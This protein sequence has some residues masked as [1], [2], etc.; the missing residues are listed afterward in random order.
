MEHTQNKLDKVAIFPPTLDLYIPELCPVCAPNVKTSSDCIHIF[1]IKQLY[2]KFESDLT[3]AFD[4][5][6]DATDGL[7]N[8]VTLFEVF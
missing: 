7:Q 5:T 8:F 3:L 2:S 6:W 4:H 1:Q